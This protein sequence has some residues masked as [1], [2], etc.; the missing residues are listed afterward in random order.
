V[1][2]EIFFRARAFFSSMRRGRAL[3]AWPGTPMGTWPYSWVLKWP[4]DLFFRRPWSLS[5]SVDLVNLYYFY[6]GGLEAVSANR[7]GSCSAFLGDDWLAF[8]DGDPFKL[9]I[10]I[11]DRLLGVLEVVLPQARGA[12]IGIYFSCL[13]PPGCFSL[14]NEDSTAFLMSV[15]FLG[16][17][18]LQ[19]LLLFMIL[20]VKNWV[21]CV[22]FPR[23]VVELYFCL[24]RVFCGMRVANRLLLSR[25]AVPLSTSAFTR[26]ILGGLP[27]ILSE[28]FADPIPPMFCTDL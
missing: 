6:S 18:N 19:L 14:S 2:G 13:L 25:L 7:E 3:T 28:D 15:E 1:R 9:W 4:T 24:A 23:S 26:G 20:V 16:K 5:G 21:S 10:W 12:I 22:P 17:M 27:S 11:Y 8:L